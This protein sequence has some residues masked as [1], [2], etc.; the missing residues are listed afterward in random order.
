[1]R[2][3]Y[4]G[5]PRRGRRWG[6]GVKAAT[7]KPSATNCPNAFP[8]AVPLRRDVLSPLGN[9]RFPPRFCAERPLYRSLLV[10]KVNP[11]AGGYCGGV[12]PLPIPN[13]EVKPACADGTAMQ[14]GRVGGRPLFLF[15]CRCL[16]AGLRSL[17]ESATRVSPAC[18]MLCD[19]RGKL[20]FVGL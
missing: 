15:R 20:R 6:A 16:V 2:A 19:M 11:L 13:R 14:C 4:E 10:K 1:M 5:R 18:S 7:P 9:R 3:P 8:R 17:P 12:P